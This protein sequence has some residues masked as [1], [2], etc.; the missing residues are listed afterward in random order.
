MNRDAMD[1]RVH[2]DRRETQE[3]MVS[4]SCGV[5]IPFFNNRLIINSLLYFTYNVVKL[6][7][8]VCVVVSE[9]L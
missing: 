1:H 2:L 7:T 3:K 4:H 8:H 6:P 5:A 9:V